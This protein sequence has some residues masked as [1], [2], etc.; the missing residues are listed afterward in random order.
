M[1]VLKAT[2]RLPHLEVEREELVLEVRVAGGGR[3]AVGL[4]GS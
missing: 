4:F 2:G 1:A 3:G